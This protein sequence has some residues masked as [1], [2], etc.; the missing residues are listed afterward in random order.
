MQSITFSTAMTFTR[1]STLSAAQT[2]ILVPQ[3]S[4]LNHTANVIDQRR[5]YVLYFY[6]ESLLSARI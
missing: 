6:G 2:I 4:S 3:S 5:M 1:C